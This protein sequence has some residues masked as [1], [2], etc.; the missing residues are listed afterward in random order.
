[1]LILTYNICNSV[2]SSHKKNRQDDIPLKKK[3]DQSTLWLHFQ[4]MKPDEQEKKKSQVS[5]NGA[6]ENSGRVTVL[7]FTPKII[8]CKISDMPIKMY[9]QFVVRLQRRRYIIHLLY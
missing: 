8:R 2:S 7:C 4:L 5:K 6:Q 9:R 1:M 3:K